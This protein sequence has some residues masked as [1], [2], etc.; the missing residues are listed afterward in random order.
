MKIRRAIPWILA[1]SLLAAV[2]LTRAEKE[3]AAELNA[4]LQKAAADSSPNTAGLKPWHLKMTAQ[5]F[6]WKGNSSGSGTI[7]EWWMAPGNEKRV[8]A[9]PDYQG[10]EIVTSDGIYRS[11]GLASEPMFISLLVSQMVDPTMAQEKVTGGKPTA[12][13]LQLAGITMPCIMDAKPNNRVADP[14]IGLYPTWCTEP[15][16]QAIRVFL[17][18]GGVAVVRNAISS[19][20]GKDIPMELQVNLGSV[21]LASAKVDDISLDGMP[22]A[23]FAPTSDMVK[24]DPSFAVVK[25][26]KFEN[27][28]SHR[29]EP[30]FSQVRQQPDQMTRGTNGLP[31][32]DVEVRLWVGEDGQIRD[33]LLQTYPEVNAAQATMDAVRRWVFHPYTGAGHAAPF[34]GT[35][36]F[37]INSTDYDRQMRQSQNMPGPT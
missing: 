33:M 21:L 23:P 37:E 27:L 25:G 28:A 3:N 8:F 34:T 29:E 4:N 13:T 14:P 7:E 15:G 22:S 36:D 16:K 32:G 19:F 2:P 10:T 30:D 31:Q 20:Q 5:L 24:A 35:L 17:D 11:T 6:D 1:V 9:F 12:R 26:K 18:N